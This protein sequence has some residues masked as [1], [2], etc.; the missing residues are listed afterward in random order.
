MIAY[1]NGTPFLGSF[2]A[3]DAVPSSDWWPDWFDWFEPAPAPRVSLSYYTA[4]EIVTVAAKRFT[5]GK[6]IGKGSYG[7]VWAATDETGMA[8]AIKDFSCG[9]G[10]GI[11][12]DASQQRAR[13][14][15]EVMQRLIQDPE[16]MRG[17]NGR[18]EMSAPR[19]IAHQFWPMGAAVPQTAFIC[20]IV[21][22]RRPGRP[23]GTWL[24]SRYERHVPA[25]MAGE[26]ELQ[27]FNLSFFTA[28]SAARE[29]IA[30]L[31][32]TFERLNSDI[33]YHRDVNARNLLVHSPLDGSPEDN[34]GALPVD[35][36]HLEFTILDF[37]SS[38]DARAW[39]GS[40]EGSWQVENPTGD[41]R[42]WGPAS[43]IRFLHGAQALAE[44]SL[45][46]QYT[47]RLD[48]F[49]LAVCT[50]ELL[51]KLHN[52]DFPSEAC[53]R[54]LDESRTTELQ[55]AQRVQRAR[56]SWGDYWAFAVGSFDRLSEYSRLACAGDQANALQVWHGLRT[57]SI[58]ELLGQK[59]NEL[60]Q[61]LHYLAE[62]CAHT[63]GGSIGRSWVQV[64]ATLGA[65]LDMVH[66]NGALEWQEVMQRVG[67]SSLPVALPEA[68]CVKPVRSEAAKLRARFQ[69]AKEQKRV[70]L[71]G[72]VF[73]L[74]GMCHGRSRSRSASMPGV[75]K[76]HH[77]AKRIVAI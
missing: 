49:A 7:Q 60:G 73:G 52:V 41:A 65:L 8:V 14:E 76:K 19:I 74:L 56:M 40:S 4:G 31:A 75:V 3:R 66:F 10:P 5:L 17:G 27:R 54:N 11:L 48:I 47:R 62:V 9:V 57:G 72:D 68:R 55:F 34:N 13:F 69:K 6:S 23:L 26:D 58:P 46:S 50:L 32:P 64:G 70:A 33:A 1:G 51:M 35:V 30:Q 37:G 16:E 59:L 12:P 2:P 24:D 71:Q 36:N 21:M 42:Y 44:T 39:L 67:A 61:D 25:L 77:K 43:W 28:A 63:P 38:T 22:T 45:L 20:R 53:I 15:V 18:P 29:M